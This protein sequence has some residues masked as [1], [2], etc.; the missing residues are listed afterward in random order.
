MPGLI[1]AAAPVVRPAALLLERGEELA[2]IDTAL[3]EARA[4]RG[5]LLVIEAEPGMGKTALLAAARTSAAAS[6]MR[7]LRAR[8]TELEHEFAFGVVRQLFERPLVE[9][10]A[11]GRSDLLEGAAGVAA[12]VLG[13]PGAPVVDSPVD[14]SFAIQHGLYWLCANLAAGGPLCL[15][16]DDAQWVDRPSLRFLAFL[17]TRLEEIGATVLIATRAGSD[18]TLLATVKSDSATE[19]IPLAPLSA[20]AVDDLI[21][22]SLGRAPHPAFVAACMHAT[23]GTPFLAVELIEAL[24]G[25]QIEPTGTAAGR[26]TVVGAQTLGRSLELRLSR[27]PESAT[28]LARAVA[29]LE[30]GD[31]VTAARLAGIEPSDG[32]DAAEELVAVGILE[33]GR[34]LRFAHPMLRAALYQEQTASERAAG[35][36]RA[37]Q[38]LAERPRRT[39]SVAQHLLLSDADGDPWVVEQLGSAAAAALRNAG[40]ESAA[41][42][43][44]R[45]LE[46]PP[47]PAQQSALLLQLGLAEASAGIDGWHEHLQ[48]AIDTA[49]DGIAAARAARELARALNRRQR[50]AEAVEVL[51]RA[52]GRLG[53]DHAELVRQL[54]AA[55]LIAAMNDPKAAAR[56]VERRSAFRRRMDADADE[57]PELLSVAAFLAVLTNDSAAEVAALALRSLSIDHG[58]ASEASARAMLA[59]VWAE[60]FDEVRPFLDSAIEAA[61]AAGDG[62]R[63]SVALATRAWL[64]LRLGELEAAE[65]DTRTALSMPALPAPPLY[66]ALNTGLLVKALVDLGRLDEAEAALELVDGEARSGSMPEGVL[67]L[68]R[69]RLRMEQGRAAEA[70]EDFLAVGRDLKEASVVG[71]AFSP[72]RAEAALAQLALGNRA[73]AQQ[74]AE[75]ELALA[76]SFGAPRALGVSLRA[77]GL[78]HGGVRGCALL[79]EAVAAFERGGAGLARARALVDLGAMLRR[80]NNRV[81]ARPYLREA[82]DTAERLGAVAVRDAAETELRASGAKPRRRSLRGPDSLTASERR[83][84]ELASHGLTNREIAQTLFVTARTVEGHLTSVFRKL[85]VESRTSLGIALTSE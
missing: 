73:A 23:R 66:R 84:A 65:L 33:P 47:A 34:P 32:A 76:R 62:G 40:P 29:I 27:L 59:L 24:R 6:G 18:C 63:L 52:A 16:V 41:S 83:V 20:R 8:G 39:E 5:R 10:T 13:L 77:A 57:S 51:D 78:A 45:A 3:A 79:R 22:T 15:V 75:E 82:L 2:R 38:A 21:R 72:W 71:P 74:L 56:T 50:S 9:A 53:P 26:V 7:V 69:G 37:A 70:L 68:A 11:R 49:P 44:R 80:G 17:L 25:E 61:R 31:L 19:V 46:E 43:L 36:R 85:H 42:F 1:E 58:L 60:C 14:S 54:E 48:D 4:G 30:Q 67:R 81:E 12:G 35:H 55:A 28:K 64:E